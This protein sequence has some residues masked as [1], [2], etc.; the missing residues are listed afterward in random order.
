MRNKFLGTGEPGYHPLR[1]IRTAL[2][3]L[4]YAVLHDFSVTYKLILSVLV[5]GAAFAFRQWLDALL[6]LVAT[7]LVLAAELLNSA[8][9]AVC[10][11]LE[12]RENERIRVI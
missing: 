12:T 7:A 5:L 8:V 11:F 4:R 10:D 3:G 2:S 6:V 9:E 1:K